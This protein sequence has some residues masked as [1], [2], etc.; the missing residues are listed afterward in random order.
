MNILSQDIFR[1]EAATGLGHGFPMAQA[2][3]SQE[4]FKIKNS[5]LLS[6][7]DGE[8]NEGSIWEGNVIGV[9]KSRILQ[10]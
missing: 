7:S 1:V 4:K 8:C 5:N 9:T 6:L 10:L 2:W 3:Q